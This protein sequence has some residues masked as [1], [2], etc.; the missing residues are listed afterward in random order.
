MPP[1]NAANWTEAEDQALQDGLKRFPHTLE[2]NERW[3][4]IASCVPT[5]S[6]K[7]CVARFKE[8]RAALMSTASGSSDGGTNKIDRAVEEK[9]EKAAEKAQKAPTKQMSEESS[10][11]AG[12]AGGGAA[13][14]AAATVA[15]TPSINGEVKKAK[16]SKQEPAKSQTKGEGKQDQ[17]KKAS[18]PSVI[19]STSPGTP[20][21]LIPG[22]AV[23]RSNH[24]RASGGAG[25]GD[26]GN[27]DNDTTSSTKRNGGQKKNEKKTAGT[28]SGVANDSEANMNTNDDAINSTNDDAGNDQGTATAAKKKRNRR[29]KKKGDDES[30]AELPSS[31]LDQQSSN[32]PRQKESD[33]GRNKKNK[34]KKNKKRQN[35][36]NGD[37]NRRRE[38]FAW[39]DEIPQGAVDPI[40][41]D[42]LVELPYPPFA[43]VA[44]EPYDVVSEWPVSPEE[45][46]RLAIG[47]IGGDAAT[48][49]GS[50]KA[51]EQK[52]IAEREL[53]VIR[54]QW[55]DA[56]AASASAFSGGADADADGADKADDAKQAISTTE[57]VGRRY[58]HLFDGQVLAYYLVS[59]LQ[60]ID[61]LNRRDLTRA[62][63]KNLDA[64]LKRHRLGKAGV[65]EAYDARGLTISSA[66]V[67]GQTDEGR[68]E[69]LQQEARTL[70]GSLFSG[71]S[72][73]QGSAAAHRQQLE[74]RA[75]AT[76][77]FENEFQRH[78]Q[79]S[80]RRQQQGSRGRGRGRGRGGGRRNQQAPFDHLEDPGVYAAEEGGMLIIDDDFNPG[81]RGGLEAA[82]DSARRHEEQ[83]GRGDGNNA[84]SGPNNFYSASHIANQYGHAARVGADNF[85]ALQATSAGGAASSSA[86]TAAA[87]TPKAPPKPKGP[88][89]SLMKISKIVQTTDP[90]ERAKQK[91]A[92]EAAR[93]RAVIAN[94]SFQVPG[95]QGTGV[96]GDGIGAAVSAVNA[97]AAA[98]S[99]G[100]AHAP[101]EGQLQRNRAMAS[102]LGVKPATM[103]NNFNSGWARPT[104]ANIELDEFGNELNAA[105]YTDALI[106][107]ANERMAELLKLE[108]R[109]KTFLADDKSS[110]QPLRAMPRDLRK[111]VHEY[112]DHWHLHTESFDPEPRRYIHCTKMRDTSAPHP[113]LS[114]AARKLKGPGTGAHTLPPV[115]PASQGADGVH[116]AQTSTQTGGQ[117]VTPSVASITPREFTVTE[118]RK[119]LKLEPRTIP[120]GQVLAEE[121]GT[122]GTKASGKDDWEDHEPA[123]RFSSLALGEKE[124]IKLTLAP[125]TK[126]LE[127]PPYQQN[128]TKTYDV[129]KA[130]ER[131]EREKKEKLEKQRKKEEKKKNILASAF[132]S[133][134]EDE[135]NGSDSSDWGE[136]QDA[137]FE[138]SDGEEW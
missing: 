30:K 124:R 121:S 97:A 24:R 10:A 138:G 42:P 73:A 134:S 79:E 46:R 19:Q 31:N 21:L 11:G 28:S 55:G 51:S 2:K 5:R 93:K 36:R 43:L 58:Y 32:Q 95:T 80:E 65:T 53:D 45:E 84:A 67:A 125:R 105:Q 54:E 70:L 122:A 101:S 20:S 123:E 62:E 8:I 114:E 91:Q 109:W 137:V 27:D 74:A 38:I 17:P 15:D 104:V 103:R 106:M 7:E 4:S 26:G 107:E 128:Q 76:P 130:R 129:A 118:E 115:R 49:S 83:T 111:F 35:E 18:E 112:S 92:T 87:P 71:D 23:N 89:K 75:R 1:T 99:G 29:K 113:L 22:Q 13:A 34:K 48:G 133:D 85:P 98:T 52:R 82:A 78:Y 81:M 94:L 136:E 6:K 126:P 100:A 57:T 119:P 72:H 33:G 108:R 117:G 9:K 127:L 61:P 96:G 77:R 40:S 116:H 63:L 14:A 90:K 120:P 110:S 44:T 37:K 135:D 60:F 68:A 131:I 39:R 64:Y 56:V 41:L 50:D 66:G 16:H 3:T 132:A 59:Q 69:I 25:S 86:E 12:A 102:A 47:S 88:S